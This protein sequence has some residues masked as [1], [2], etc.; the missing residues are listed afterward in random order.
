MEDPG[1]GGCGVIADVMLLNH[2][3]IDHILLA[4]GA[5]GLHLQQRV[6]FLETS[7]AAALGSMCATRRLASGA[8]ASSRRGRHVVVNVL[9]LRKNVIT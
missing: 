8:A 2:A 5:Y 7:D 9:S 3:Q 1:G 4:D 6:V